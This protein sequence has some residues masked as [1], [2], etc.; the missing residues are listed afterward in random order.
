MAPLRAAAFA[1]AAACALLRRARALTYFTSEAANT[2]A[3]LPQNAA[4][5]VSRCLQQNGCW[6]FNN[7]NNRRLV[8]LAVTEF[9]KL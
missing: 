8:T 7:N 1:A 5:R 6:G 2:V 3:K 9:L 4:R